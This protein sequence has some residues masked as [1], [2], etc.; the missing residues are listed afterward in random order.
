MPSATRTTSS[1]KLSLIGISSSG[2]TNSLLNQNTRLNDVLEILLPLQPDLSAATKPIPTASAL[3]TT[4]NCFAGLQ[5]SDHQDVTEEES[6][7][8]TRPAVDYTE[9][10][11]TDPPQTASAP[12][13]DVI[14]QND[15]LAEWIEL[16]FFLCEMDGILEQVN[17]YWRQVANDQFPIPLAACLSTTAF[18]VVGMISSRISHIAPDH[19]SLI[20]KW[21]KHAQ[22]G[23][24]IRFTGIPQLASSFGGRCAGG[25]A[26]RHI[27]QLLYHAKTWDEYQEILPNAGVRQAPAEIFKSCAAGD[28]DMATFEIDDL[29]LDK[30]Q[31]SM[32]QLLTS[33]RAIAAIEP[34]EKEV[35]ISEPLLP[36]L[37][38]FLE[39][40]KLPLCFPLVYGMEML[41]STYKA[42]LWQGTNM[43]KKNCRIMALKFAKEV[44]EA[45]S[46]GVD[47]LEAIR[48]TG[49]HSMTLQTLLLEIL[50]GLLSLDEYTGEV[51]FDLYYQSPWVAGC[52]MVEILDFAYFYGIRLSTELGYVCA[53]LH[54]YNALRCLDAPIHRI[55]LLDQLCQ[56]FL[57]PIFLGLLPKENFSSHFRRAMGQGLY[58]ERPSNTNQ[59]S[60]LTMA[61][62]ASKRD[63]DRHSTSLFYTLTSS[64]FLPSMD[65]WTRV[66]I[67]PGVKQ[68]SR[69][70]VAQVERE[71]HGVPFNDPLDKI[72][73]ALM[74]EF[75][76]ELPIQ[77]TNLF[78]IFCFCARLLHDLSQI[79]NT[80]SGIFCAAPR[81][82]HSGFDMVDLLLTEIVDHLRDDGKRLLLRHWRP[83][84]RVK[85]VFAR[86]DV[87]VSLSDYQ[88]SI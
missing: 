18:R 23:V 25:F 32:R 67:Q 35:H 52:H 79:A 31:E 38:T 42:F 62:T 82:E 66:Y 13:D 74:P 59:H 8:P 4:M 80:D 45:M 43:T 57:E 68:P 29:A 37:R 55:N 65:F 30:M 48:K 14:L 85:R 51:R 12:D 22:K 6:G 2:M 88:W 64:N 76:G 47:A 69:S 60:R 28:Y 11:P 46:E 3:S 21:L 41:L 27:G 78:A 73:T 50:A 34:S 71:L 81:G 7:A 86:V 10:L 53:V 56:V 40:P 58:R 63:I 44:R 33:K 15:D 87:G 26:L 70:Q 39:D 24:K 5:I 49:D 9:P 72:K 77:R 36:P 19:N 83:L 16:S 1:T 54:L 20:Q 84:N 61:S 75:T 17:D